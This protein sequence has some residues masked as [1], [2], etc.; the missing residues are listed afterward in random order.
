MKDF[1][2]FDLYKGKGVPEGKISTAYYFIFANDERTLT[3]SE[4]EASMAIVMDGLKREFLIEI[5]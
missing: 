4:V 1:G 3:D 2:I 5:R